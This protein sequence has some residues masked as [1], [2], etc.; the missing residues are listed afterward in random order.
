MT[1]NDRR[2]TTDL[3]LFTGLCRKKPDP[4]NGGECRL[5]QDVLDNG[6]D[7]ALSGQSAQV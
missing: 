5:S 1:S 2:Q 3:L 6:A 4:A 7:M